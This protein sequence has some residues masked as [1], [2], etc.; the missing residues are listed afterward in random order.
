MVGHQVEI[1]KNGRLTIKIEGVDLLFIL[2][3]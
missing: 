3:F 1:D 2:H